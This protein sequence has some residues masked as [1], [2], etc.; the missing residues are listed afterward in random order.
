MENNQ[1]EFTDQENV[2]VNDLAQKMKYVG[3]FGIILGVVEI[4]SS[5]F[6][7]KGGIISGVIS[8]IV[9]VWTINASKFFQKIVD[10]TGNDMSN[11]MS[12]LIELKKLYGLQYWTQIF[13]IIL[14]VLL[15]IFLILGIG[16]LA[17]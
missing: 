8:I 16:S 11:L 5:F 6:G 12:A 3:I 1:Y 14:A 17:K 2:L 7:E 13:G 15:I 10:T 4:L 9:G